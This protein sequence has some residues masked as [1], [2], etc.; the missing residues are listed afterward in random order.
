MDDQRFTH[1]VLA[2]LALT[3]CPIGDPNSTTSD[4]GEAAEDSS[5][6]SGPIAD[7]P[8]A[9]T[10]TE[11]ST[12]GDGD[13]DPGDGDGDATETGDP[14][15]RWAALDVD[16]AFIGWL[17]TPGPDA[18]FDHADVFS[19][20]QIDQ[21]SAR[22]LFLTLDG[23]DASG[24]YGFMLVAAG[25]SFTT[26]GTDSVSF[27]GPG[28]T[29]TPHDRVASY[30][31]SG[32]PVLA[33]ACT[34]EMIDAIA[35]QLQIHYWTESTFAGWMDLRWPGAAGQIVSTQNLS[36]FYL[37]PREQEWPEMLTAVS[38]R[39]PDGTCMELAA[40]MNAC[41]I[42]FIDAGWTPAE[43]PGGYSLAELP[44]E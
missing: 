34:D 28:C 35:D 11:T 36:Q 3:A 4:G 40:P 8:P 41:A 24:E 5:G 1:V 14:V 44:W 38:V 7:L 33:D 21:G 42:R 43:A 15:L 25:L 17:S 22:D 18:V 26:L 10:D 6:T 19:Q 13:G 39:Q 32:A 2:T 20:T 12:S 29:G 27:T 16:A 9:E 30:I 23:L 31:D 37:L